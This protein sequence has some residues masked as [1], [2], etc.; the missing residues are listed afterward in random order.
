M[1]DRTVS[2]NL[3]DTLGL[4][5]LTYV[6]TEDELAPQMVNAAIAFLK[7]FPPEADTTAS[8]VEKQKFEMEI[9]DLANVMPFQSR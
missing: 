2:Q 3:R 5:L 8:V 9:D 6:Q 7:Q 1:T 4:R